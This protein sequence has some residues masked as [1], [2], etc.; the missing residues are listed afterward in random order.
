MAGQR[1]DPHSRSRGRAAPPLV[2]G[3]SADA[4]LAAPVPTGTPPEAHDWLSIS[5]ASRDGPSARGSQLARWWTEGGEPLTDGRSAARGSE[6]DVS[7]KLRK[8]QR[9]DEPKTLT[10]RVGLQRRVTPP[11][12]RP[13]VVLTDAAQPHESATSRLG[14]RAGYAN[15]GRNRNRRRPMSA[16]SGGFYRPETLESLIHGRA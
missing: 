4:R 12:S 5:A 15:G 11:D 8:R 2:I 14:Q 9:P 16:S 1:T 7:T 3:R 13:S 6:Q 10:P